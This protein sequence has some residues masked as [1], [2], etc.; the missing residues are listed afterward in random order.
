MSLCG[1]RAR[2]SLRPLF[3]RAVIPFTGLCLD[4]AVASQR[5]ITLLGWQ[6]TSFRGWRHKNSVCSD[7]VF[8]FPFWM[9]WSES[10]RAYPLCPCRPRV[11]LGTVLTQQVLNE[12]TNEWMIYLIESALHRF[13]TV[14]WVFSL[15]G[16]WKISQNVFCYSPQ[17]SVNRSWGWWVGLIDW[18]NWCWK[19]LDL[20]CKLFFWIYDCV[21]LKLYTI[22]SN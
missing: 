1:W 19:M 6:H 5:P 3:I 13:I 4:G 2:S 18:K 11:V 15:L 22:C 14:K 17:M 7:H 21:A 10:Q 12:W 20:E 8:S 9:V 16:F